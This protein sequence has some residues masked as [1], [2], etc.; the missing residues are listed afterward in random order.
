M[1]PEDMEK[2]SREFMR[3]RHSLFAYICSLVDTYDSSEDIFQ[4]VWTSVL[5]THRRG[6]EIRDLHSWCITVARRQIMQH[7]R[8]IVKEKKHLV[9]VD[10][11]VLDALQE[12]FERKAADEPAWDERI[13]ALHEC[14]AKLPGHSRRALRMRYFAGAGMEEL[15]QALKKTNKNLYMILSRLRRWMKDCVEE[16]LRGEKPHHEPV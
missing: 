6:Q 12:A 5:E 10:E 16:S 1:M 14:I 3:M 2:I 7:R 8:D 11:N 9:M 13:T 15:S 4:K